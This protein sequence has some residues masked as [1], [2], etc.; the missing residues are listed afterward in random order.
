MDRRRFFATG[1]ALTP[2]AA[3][4]AACGKK[5][6][7]PE[8]MQPIVWDRDTCVRCSMVISDR[9]FAAEMRGGPKNTIFKF[10]DIGCAA[11]WLRDK[12]ADHPWMAEAATRFWVADLASKGNDVHWLDARAAHY[13]TKTSPMGYNFGALPHPEAGTVDFATMREH[14]LAKGK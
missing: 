3:A 11:F 2:L 13:A 7:W 14:V 10:D 4:L 6:D 8:G 1:F 9:R 5:G 12:A